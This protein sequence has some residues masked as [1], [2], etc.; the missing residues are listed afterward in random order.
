MAKLRKKHNKSLVILIPVLILVVFAMFLTYSFANF[1]IV[2]IFDIVAAN[3][4]MNSYTLS[5]D[6]QGCTSKQLLIINHLVNF[7]IQLFQVV[8]LL[9][10]GI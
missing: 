10:A 2:K 1:R 7:V 4:N 9:V 3:F 6:V 5:Y 8:I